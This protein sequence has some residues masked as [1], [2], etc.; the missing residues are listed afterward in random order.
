MRHLG[1]EEVGQL[2]SAL[3]ETHEATVYIEET[4]LDSYGNTIVRPSTTSVVI[5]CYLSPRVTAADKAGADSPRWSLVA[6]PT[7]SIGKWSKII[8]LG[9]TF[10]VSS[11]PRLAGPDGSAAQSV[12]CELI[13]QR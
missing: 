4:V 5:R 7:T 10:A 9:R 12:Q 8:A 1:V 3:L 2:A 6:P 11:W 13:E